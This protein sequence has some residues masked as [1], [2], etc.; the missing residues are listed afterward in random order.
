MI[1]HSSFSHPS[2]V[3]FIGY[4]PLNFTNADDRHKPLMMMEFAQKGSLHS[5]IQKVKKGI[6]IEGWDDTKRLMVI[7]GIA[8]SMSYLHS[9]DILHRDLKPHNILID[10]DF[11][12]KLTDFGLSIEI[13]KISGEKEKC[14]KGTANYIAP[15]IWKD[16]KY[17]KSSD[18]YLL[19]LSTS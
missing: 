2:V 10:N 12:P 18:V 1:L 7:Y 6:K 5:I 13:S 15:E 4:S 9:K 3:K 16:I 17:S 8:A 19:F 11:Y 14:V